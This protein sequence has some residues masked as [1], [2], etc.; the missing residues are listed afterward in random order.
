MKRSGA[1]AEDVEFI[2]KLSPCRLRIASLKTKRRTIAAGEHTEMTDQPDPGD[3]DRWARLRFA[4]RGEV[5][6]GEA[7][8][9]G[10]L[11]L[12]LHACSGN[13]LTAHGTCAKP[14][15][16][17][18]DHRSRLAVHVQCGLNE[19]IDT[20]VLGFSRVLMLRAL[21][22]AI[23]TDNSASGKRSPRGSTRK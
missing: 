6:N 23:E 17:V 1:P 2:A 14:L 18:V 3:R 10:A 12:D 20:L 9:C 15:A 21:S 7:A 8:R 13:V 5:R 16:V 22:S 19:T 11:W 4:A